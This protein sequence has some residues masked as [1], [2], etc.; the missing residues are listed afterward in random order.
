MGESVV[1][2]KPKPPDRAKWKKRGVLFGIVR[3]AREGMSR[4][5]CFKLAGMHYQ[6]GFDWMAMGR[7]NPEKYP[8]L[9]RF[10]ELLE[11]AEAQ[12]RRE[13]VE[14]V[15]DAALSRRDNT[16]QAA[17]TVLERRDPENWGK[18]ERTIVEHEN[19]PEV[20]VQ[21][22]VI[23]DPETRELSRNFLRRVTSPGPDVTIGPGVGDESE[24]TG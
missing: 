19:T 21:I 2:Y 14:A 23:N 17:M 16:W 7:R 15:T 10:T 18:R 1:K 11:R 24:E 4:S 5:D 12:F 3:R 9:V 20:N 13:M 22:A 6:T 8:E